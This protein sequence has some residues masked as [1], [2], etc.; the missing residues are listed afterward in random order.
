MG[1]ASSVQCGK[2]V[3]TNCG[4]SEVAQR[5][6]GANPSEISCIRPLSP[7]PDPSQ[8]C[9]D[10]CEEIGSAFFALQYG[11]E[12]WCGS[13]SAEPTLYGV[14]SGCDMACG[15][16][17][18]TCGGSYAMDVYK[19]DESTAEASVASVDGAEYLGCYNDDP[20]TMEL[21]E[22][23]DSMTPEVSVSTYKL[24][25]L[26]DDSGSLRSLGKVDVTRREILPSIAR[27]FELVS[28][29]SMCPPVT[30]I[31]QDCATFCSGYTYFGLQYSVECYCG[32]A[33]VDVDQNGEGSC[34]MA[35][36]GDPSSTCGGVYT[37]TVYQ[38][39]DPG[40]AGGVLA[41]AE[42]SGAEYLG[43]FADSKESRILTFE[44]AD[45]SM[46]AEVRLPRFYQLQSFP[47]HVCAYMV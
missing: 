10:Y 46:T 43:C 7:S 40:D 9:Y 47:Y 26:H 44:D 22:K 37:M 13:D 34:S 25:I 33:S 41:P 3:Y 18:G 2:S 29:F 11:T 28:M 45:A 30:S 23:S 12:C 38:F 16:G 4:N 14:S 32:G 20:R 35:C 1:I 19:Y 21:A 5:V 36:G 39:D 15:S 27:L 8:L 31:A 17:G 6:L 42:V 24:W